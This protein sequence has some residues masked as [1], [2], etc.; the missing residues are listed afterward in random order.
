MFSKKILIYPAMGCLA[1]MGNYSSWADSSPQLR[2][3]K[4]DT[5]EI[6]KGTI[7]AMIP[8]HPAAGTYSILSGPVYCKNINSFSGLKKLNVLGELVIGKG[9]LPIRGPK[10]V[11]IETTPVDIGEGAVVWGEKDVN[12]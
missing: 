8:P 12:E 6:G 9:V 2:D 11:T 1:V 5:I 4:E 3:I 10:T 7:T